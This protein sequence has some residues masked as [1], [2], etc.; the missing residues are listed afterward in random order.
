M[1]QTELQKVNGSINRLKSQNTVLL[2]T[3]YKNINDFDNYI[4]FFNTVFNI[5]ENR[6]SNLSNM[7]VN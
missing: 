7:T 3:F 5:E 2:R 4:H 6:T 1:F